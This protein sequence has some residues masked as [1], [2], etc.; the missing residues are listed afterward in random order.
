MVY[1]AQQLALPLPRLINNYGNDLLCMPIVLKICQYAI[2]YV[3]N[4]KQLIIPVKLGLTLTL[5]YALYFEWLLPR[6]NDRYTA[7][8]LD[9]LCYFLGLLFFMWMERVPINRPM[10]S[11]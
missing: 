11:A 3:K 4:N 5:F 2:R 1:T 8:G 9:V 6:Y 7:D 10:K